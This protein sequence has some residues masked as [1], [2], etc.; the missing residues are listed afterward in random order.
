M[1]SGKI[2][3]IYHFNRP[4]PSSLVSLFQS[5]AKCK[6]ILMKMSLICMKME[7]YAELIFI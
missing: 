1:L 6:I 5:E 3:E 2:C 7:L 4:F